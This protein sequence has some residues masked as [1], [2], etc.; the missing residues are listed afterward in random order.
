LGPQHS[1]SV[2]VAAHLYP[3]AALRSA[4]QQ[5]AHLCAVDIQDVAAEYFDITLE[6]T[7]DPPDPHLLDEYLTLALMAMIEQRSLGNG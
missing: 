3:V 6:P 7:S 5:L 4:A 2:R 1:R